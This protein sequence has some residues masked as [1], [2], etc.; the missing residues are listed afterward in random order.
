MDSGDTRPISI[1]VAVSGAMTYRL[2][3]NGCFTYFA[4]DPAGG[5]PGSSG[6]GFEGI[7]DQGIG[8]A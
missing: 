2:L 3:G 7:G 5:V 6:G 8:R 1:E 4:Y